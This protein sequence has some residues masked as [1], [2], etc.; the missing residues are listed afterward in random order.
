MTFRQ[1]D[2]HIKEKGIKLWIDHGGNP[3][4]SVAASFVHRQPGYTPTPITS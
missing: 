4:A 2:A 1:L 3:D